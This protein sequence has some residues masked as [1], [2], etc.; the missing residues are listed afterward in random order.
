MP[1]II[2][3]FLASRRTGFYFAVTRK[4]WLV[5]EMPMELIGHE[6]NKTS[7]LPISRVFMLLIRTM[8]N[9]CGKLIKVEALPE[10][11]KGYFRHQLESKPSSNLILRL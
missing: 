1:D 4:E 11:W 2:K 6:N 5:P 3:R 8:S 10:S 9:R 7:A